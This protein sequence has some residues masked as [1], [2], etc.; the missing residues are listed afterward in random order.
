MPSLLV[1]QLGNLVCFAFCLLFLQK[2]KEIIV[3][4]D[5]EK[6]ETETRKEKSHKWERLKKRG[7]G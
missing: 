1:A 2:A 7:N 6:F 4:V 5:S 3:G